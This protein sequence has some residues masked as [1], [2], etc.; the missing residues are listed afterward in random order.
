MPHIVL[1]CCNTEA[2]IQQMDI[3]VSVRFSK[4]YYESPKSNLKLAE[5]KED[6]ERICEKY[7]DLQYE[8]ESQMSNHEYNVF[9]KG[10]C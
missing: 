7:F 5:I 8:S 10:C 9:N 4:E 6:L 3:H 1:T 2:V